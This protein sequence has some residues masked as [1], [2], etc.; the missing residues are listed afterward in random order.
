MVTHMKTTI[1]ISNAIFKQ[2]RRLAEEKGITFR[3]AVEGGLRLLLK[4]QPKGKK[5]FRLRHHTF[6]G[7]GP[8]PGVSEGNWGAVREKIYEGRGG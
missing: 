1:D 5:P 8:A 6:A 2:S 3:E 4:T 7:K